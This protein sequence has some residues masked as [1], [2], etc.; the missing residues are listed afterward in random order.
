VHGD[1]ERHA[2]RE[3][4]R[5]AVPPGFRSYVRRYFQSIAPR[6]P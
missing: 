1:Y 2:E 6:T 3:L 4:D 5:E